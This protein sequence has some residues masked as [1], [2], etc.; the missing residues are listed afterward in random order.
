ME[1]L[2][3]S[4]SSPKVVESCSPGDGEN[5]FTLLLC[6]EPDRR[7]STVAVKRADA[8]SKS[9]NL[10]GVWSV[11]GASPGAQ[12]PASFVLRPAP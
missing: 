3:P 5:V 12:S 6:K 8:H 10:R 9:T 1:V 11:L 4:S 2:C 7:L